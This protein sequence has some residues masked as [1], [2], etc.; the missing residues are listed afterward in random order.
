MYGVF[1]KTVRLRRGL[2]NEQM[3]EELQECLSQLCPMFP[4][5]LSLFSSISICNRLF[6]KGLRSVGALL[7]IAMF[8]TKF[9]FTLIETSLV[10]SALVSVSGADPDRDLRTSAAVSMA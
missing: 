2:T 6:M 4:L 1:R 8:V 9:E 5:S 7:Q 10:S 3:W